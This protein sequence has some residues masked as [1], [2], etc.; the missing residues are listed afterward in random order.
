ML[1]TGLISRALRKLKITRK[2]KVLHA[3]ERD[4][5]EGQRKRRDSLGEIKGIDPRRL[6]FVDET[7]AN[8]STDFTSTTTWSSTMR[9]IRYDECRRVPL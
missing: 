4:T 9:S 1:A 8:T 5:P 3:Q 6:V 7:G 2:K